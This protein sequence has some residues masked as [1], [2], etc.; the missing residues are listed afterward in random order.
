MAESEPPET[1]ESK[2]R[3]SEAQDKLPLLE[4]D[5]EEDEYFVPQKRKRPQASGGRFIRIILYT[6]RQPILSFVFLQ[7]ILSVVVVPILIQ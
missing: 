4:E 5:E 3:P 7:S 2:K 1:P 6:K